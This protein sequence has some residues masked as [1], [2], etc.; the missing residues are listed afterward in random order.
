MR[1]TIDKAGRL[2]IPKP[3]RDHLGLQPGEVE[4]T[5]DGAGLRMEPL[6][7][8]SLDEREGRFVIPAGGAEITDA[9]VA[10]LRDA[11]QR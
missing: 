1:A 11:A 3:L 5:A 4:V 7:G 10:T 6:A 2:V 8:D 9:V